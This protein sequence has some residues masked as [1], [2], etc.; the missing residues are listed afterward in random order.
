M[1]VSRLISAVPVLLLVTLIGFFMMRMVPCDPT[2]VMGGLQSTPQE[3]EAIREALGLDQ[4]LTVQRGR[5][6]AGLAR[7]DLGRSVLLGQQVSSIA[8]E[9]LPV[10]FSIAVYAFF[11][12]ILR[13]IVAGV[14]STL[15]QNT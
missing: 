5:W 13:G 1:I 12:T 6:L 2:I 11:L 15:R 14:V 8:A 3:R 9:R 4:P 7:G 10:T